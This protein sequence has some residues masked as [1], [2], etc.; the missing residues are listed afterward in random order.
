M[1]KEMP[2]SEDVGE[3]RGSFCGGIDMRAAYFER[4]QLI[5]VRT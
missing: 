5:G 2:D 1:L 3:V 4:R